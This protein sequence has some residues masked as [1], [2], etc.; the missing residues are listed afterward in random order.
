MS[1]ITKQIIKGNKKIE[2]IYI[3]IYIYIWLLN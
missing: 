1:F 3:Y 2:S